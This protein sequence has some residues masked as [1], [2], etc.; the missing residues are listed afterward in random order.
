MDLSIELEKDFRLNVRTTALIRYNNEI[1]LS[2]KSNEEY[3]SLPG[4]RVK[5][6]EDSRI[7]LVREL[8]EELNYDIREEELRLVRIVENFFTYADGSK[9]HEYLFIYELLLP[10]K[11]YNGDF[12]NLENPLMDMK[13]MREEEFTVTNVKPDLCKSIIASPEFRHVILKEK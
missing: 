5:M 10:E 7:A 9:F 4:G 8:K 2:K 3:Y 6:G 12:K 13:W 1:L 11:Y